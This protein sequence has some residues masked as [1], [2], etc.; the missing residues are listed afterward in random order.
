VASFGAP[1]QTVSAQPAGR[2]SRSQPDTRR[3][4][5]S[6]GIVPALPAALRRD[7]RTLL[8][9]QCWCWGADIRRDE[10]N[11]LLEYGFVRVRAVASTVGMT[12]RYTLT[13]STGRRI[14]LWGWGLLYA[15]A[16]GALHLGRYQF[17]PTM[18]QDPRAGLDAFEPQQMTAFH[19]PETLDQ[20]RLSLLMLGEA[21]R[22]IAEYE[23]WVLDRA[24]LDYRREVVGAWK[25]ARVSAE[26]V[27]LAWR[28]LAARIGERV[29]G[30]RTEGPAV[31]WSRRTETSGEPARRVLRSSQRGA[32]HAG[33]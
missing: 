16:R 8:H 31:D 33:D 7:G 29:D 6:E 21:C 3:R 12:S 28:Q 15:D 14:Q 20:G 23:Q 11:L 19:A 13:P 1:S 2:A 5:A 24:G 22:W 17:T 10:G 18:A 26:R 32:R 27:S 4:R 9:Q 25:K 30:V